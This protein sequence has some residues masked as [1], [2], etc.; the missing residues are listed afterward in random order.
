M[1]LTAASAAHDGGMAAVLR[2]ILENEPEDG[3]FVGAVSA[4]STLATL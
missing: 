1:G 4:V 2:R 3:P